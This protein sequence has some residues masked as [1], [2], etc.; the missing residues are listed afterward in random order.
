MN[1]SLEKHVIAASDATEMLLKRLPDMPWEEKVDVAA[2]LRAVV[3]NC[4][5]L[6]K[7]IKDD[8]K[9]RLRNK[10]GVV[11]GDVF[12]AS[13]NYNDVTRFQTEAFKE[14]HH[15]LYDEWCETKPEGRVTFEPR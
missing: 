1:K 4:A 5:T 13:L 11:L 7:A 12:K 10:D 8:I 9:K 6:D 15:D 14:A 2:R 3:K